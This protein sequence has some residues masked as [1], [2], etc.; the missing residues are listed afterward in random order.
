MVLFIVATIH[1][2]VHR[3]AQSTETFCIP[4]FLSADTSEGQLLALLVDNLHL[5][6][7]D[8]AV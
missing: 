4:K 3:H 7:S 6:H 5:G 1:L 8:Q 2:E